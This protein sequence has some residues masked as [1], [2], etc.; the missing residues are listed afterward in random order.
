M[1]RM[2][3]AMDWF[4]RVLGGGMILM[5]LVV[6]FLAAPPLGEAA[7]QAVWPERINAAAITSVVGCSY[8]AVSFL[9]IKKGQR[10][11][12]WCIIAFILLSLLA[13]FV[14]QHFEVSATRLLILAGT[15]NGILM[16]IILGVILLAAYRPALMG[17]YRHPWW[18]GLFGAIAWLATVYLAYRTAIEALREC[19]LD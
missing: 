17:D 2:L 10:R 12:A 6:L 9:G 7:R 3:T 16:P 4:S 1:P 15:I 13:A 11:Q 18:A 5:T 14:L 8:T 19:V